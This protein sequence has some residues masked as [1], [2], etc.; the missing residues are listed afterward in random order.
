MF[1]SNDTSTLN[2]F[3]DQQMTPYNEE[4]RTKSILIKVGFKTAACLKLG[5]M[6]NFISSFTPFPLLKDML[7]NLT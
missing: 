6:S 7:E 4:S 5:G 3:R 1:Y 2:S